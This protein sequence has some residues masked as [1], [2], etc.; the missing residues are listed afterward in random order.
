MIKTDSQGTIALTKNPKQHPK[1]K[2]IDIWYH[3]VQDLI[4]KGIIKLEYC[5]MANMVADIL[6]KGLPQDTHE[7]HTKMM[8]LKGQD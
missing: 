8:G 5:P 4:E 1:T 3:F 2:H 7:Q 6:T